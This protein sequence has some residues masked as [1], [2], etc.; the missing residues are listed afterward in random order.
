[1]RIRDRLAQRYGKQSVFTGIDSIPVGSDFLKYINSEI[2]SSDCVVAI[3]GPRWFQGGHDHGAGLED[4]PT[5]CGLKSGALTR[6]IHVVPVVVN[7]ARM[8]KP[9]ELPD[10]MRSFAYRNAAIVDLGL[11]FQNDTDHYSLVR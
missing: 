11:N 5:M 2:A 10:C 3:V 7:G 8:P 9:A 1:M 4:G 6:D